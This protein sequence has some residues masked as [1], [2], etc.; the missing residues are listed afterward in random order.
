VERG[1]QN[2]T[3][4]VLLRLAEALAVPLTDLLRDQD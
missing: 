2:I 1:R 3:L 4:E